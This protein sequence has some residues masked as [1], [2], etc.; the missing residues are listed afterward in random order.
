M[1]T[2]YPQPAVHGTLTTHKALAEMTS[3]EGT[4]WLA[5]MRERLARKMW[6]ERAYLSRR[7]ARG[8]YTP[9]DDAYEADQALEAE[10]L[11]FLDEI[12]RR[13]AQEA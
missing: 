11:A 8:T 4:A 10:L 13:L 7:A 12:A 9:T 6:R 3:E 5:S 1:N 2:P